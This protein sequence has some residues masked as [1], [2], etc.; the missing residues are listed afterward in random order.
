MKQSYNVPG[1]CV[2]VVL[3]QIERKGNV[4]PLIGVVGGSR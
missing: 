2:V 3:L 1:Q 4:K